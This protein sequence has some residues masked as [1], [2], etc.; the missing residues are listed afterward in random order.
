MDSIRGAAA[1]RSRLRQVEGMLQALEIVAAGWG[2]S[3]LFIRS[4]MIEGGADFLAELVA[5][6][7]PGNRPR[8]TQSP[9][10]RGFRQAERSLVCES[11]RCAVWR[12]M[13]G[14]TCDTARCAV[15]AASRS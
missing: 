8:A 13:R 2:L 5:G 6:H 14:E 1:G 3:L 10:S 9:L 11:R 12:P 15:Q 4:E 7:G